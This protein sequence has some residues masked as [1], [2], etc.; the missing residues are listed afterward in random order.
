[1]S[2]IQKKLW[3]WPDGLIWKITDKPT[4]KSRWG[5]YELFISLIQLKATETIL[6]VGI[7]P[8]AF[9]GTKFLE[10]WYPYP[11]KIVALA[12]D[13]AERFKDFKQTFPQVHLIFGDRKSLSF[14]DNHFDI[15]FCN[16][17]V[18]HVGNLSEQKKFVEEFVRIGKKVFITTPNDY[19]SVDTHTLVPF[20]H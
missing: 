20:A 12:N 1:M 8:Y 13:K 16:A 9:R 19:C 7:A 5:K 3:Q 2:W 17:V 10:Q 15:V 18:E 11:K 14:P 4:R 6:D